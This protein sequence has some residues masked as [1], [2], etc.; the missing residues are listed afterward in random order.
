MDQSLILWALIGTC[1]LA[2]AGLL[3]LRLVSP[4][5]RQPLPSERCFRDGITRTPQ[6]LPSLLDSRKDGKTDQVSL[7]IIVPSYNETARLPGMLEETL[8][9][10]R[11]RKRKL[12]SFTFEII[13]VDDGSKD[14]TSE[15]ALDLA[16]TTD[17]P[18]IRVLT[19]EKNRGKGGAVAQGM[20]HARGD[21][22]LFADA[23]GATRIDDLTDL[24][25][26]IKEIEKDGLGIAIGSRSHLVSTD[27][28]VKVGTDRTRCLGAQLTAC[29]GRIIVRFRRGRRSGT[30]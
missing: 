25:D 8:R 10:C 24:L 4:Q 22:L 5:P 1:T 30:F 19:F 26:R 13:V 11:A 16:A 12:R 27:A 14:G 9:Y 23:D 3:A 29:C 18:E 6:P 28:V 17:A 2:V 20:L 21:Y 15:C 7:S